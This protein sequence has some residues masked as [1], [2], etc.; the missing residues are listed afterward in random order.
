MAGDLKLWE[1]WLVILRQERADPIEGPGTVH[2][3][4]AAGAGAI[5]VFTK[6]S[7]ASNDVG[8]PYEIG[9]A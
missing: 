6:G 8:V 4:Y 2:A 9:T 3:E 5:A 1:F 7:H